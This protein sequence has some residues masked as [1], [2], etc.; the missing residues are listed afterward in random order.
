MV[1]GPNVWFP[2]PYDIPSSVMQAYALQDDEYIKLKDMA[3]GKRWVQKG[4]ALVFLEPSWKVEITSAKGDTGIRKA[5]VLKAYE[6][7]RLI[8]NVTGKV[9]MVKGEDTVFPG[10]NEELLDGDKMTAI[11]LKVNQYVKVLDQA[12]GEI[13]VVAGP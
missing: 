7:V 11:D 10:P 2:K 5:W 12:S 6:Y 4:K 3:T 9:T 1:K 8:D 13:R